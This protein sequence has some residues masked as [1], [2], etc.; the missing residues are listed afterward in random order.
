MRKTTAVG[1]YMSR[2]PQE[3][4]RREPLS[5]AIRTMREH[6][7]RHVPVMDGSHVFGVLSRQDVQEACLEHGARSETMPIGEVCRREALLVVSPL[8]P[9]TEVA[10]QMVARNATSALVMD[11]NVL[12]GIFTSIDALRVLAEL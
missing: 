8:A 4:D 9:I 5:A 7:I 10:G 2:L 11:Q 12:V 3:V 1:Q 6:D